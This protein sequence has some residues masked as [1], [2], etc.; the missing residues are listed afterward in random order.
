MMRMEILKAIGQLGARVIN[1][2]ARLRFFFTGSAY[3]T[4][5]LLAKRARDRFLIAS[6]QNNQVF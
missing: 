3:F 1:S 6:H 4:E 2:L 5:R